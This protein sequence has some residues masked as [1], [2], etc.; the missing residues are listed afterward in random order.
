M[1]PLKCVGAGLTF[2]ILGCARAGVP[3][4]GC[5]ATAQQALFN[6]AS[7]ESYLG[8]A[9]SQIAAIVQVV[10]AGPPDGSFCSGT[11]IK[12]NWVVTA[13]HCLQ[14]F[15]SQVV[16]R[17]DALSSSESFP[18]IARIGHPTADV[19]LLR[20]GI[21][22]LDA[23]ADGGSTKVSPIQPAGTIETPLA[24]GS[25]VEMAGYGITEAHATRHLRFLAETIVNIADD[26]IT[27]NGF[28][29]SGACDGDSGG[30]LLVRGPD[31]TPLLAGVM[32]LGARSCV[33]DDTYVRLDPLQDWIQET[34]GL[35]ASTRNECGS[36]TEQGRCLYGTALWCTG[37]ELA[38]ETC[39]DGTTCGWDVSLGGFRCVA[40]SA[41]PCEGVDSV[42]ACVGD[43]AMSCNSGALLREECAPCDVCRVEG[44]TG[45]PTCTQ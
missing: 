35:S 2:W 38:A 7:Q 14:L 13:R 41:D 24:Y 5:P 23:N 6:G 18:V 28:G 31:G 20:I 30:P 36:I 42:G 12:P 9:P 3:I 43:V 22:G 25:V 26:A 10:S 45:H 15:S 1:H 17:G 4:E 40:P 16:I 34:V 21:A 27:V 33:E 11:F 19:A 8:L 29:K 32:S 44:H 39:I 37:T